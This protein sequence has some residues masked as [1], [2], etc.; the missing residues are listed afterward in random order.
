ML[1]ENEN[2]NTEFMIYSLIREPFL[3]LIFIYLPCIKSSL[4]GISGNSL[5]NVLLCFMKL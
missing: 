4:S 3:I 5:W 1:G 2:T